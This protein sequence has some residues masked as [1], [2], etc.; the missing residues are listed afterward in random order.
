MTVQV[1]DK[2]KIVATL[3]MP[4]LTVSQNVF[5]ANYN[6]SGAASDD[7]VTSDLAAWVEEMFDNL[8]SIMVDV[9]SISEVVV[10]KLIDDTPVTWEEIGTEPG[11]F[12][13]LETG[14]MVAHGVAAV[15]RIATS[16]V[17]SIARKYIAGFSEGFS[18]ELGW[19]AGAI[20]ALLAFSVDWITG[21]PTVAGRNYTGG[22]VS[23]SDGSFRT[24]GLNAV[25]S[26]IQGYQRR[27]K[28]GVGI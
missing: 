10:S 26:G 16:G 2:M 23:A 19:T 9:V 5:Y 8:D 28:P 24:F 25:V 11:V 20:T 14:D 17:K 4:G 3:A 21:P 7:D 15:V 6:G 13:G 22:I 18:S 27:R 1:G 12:V